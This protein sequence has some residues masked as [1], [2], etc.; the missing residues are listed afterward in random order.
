VWDHV[1]ALLAD[2]DR[3]IAPFEHFAAVVDPGIA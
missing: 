3:L 1:A 2:P